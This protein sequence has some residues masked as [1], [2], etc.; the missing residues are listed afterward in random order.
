MPR[1]PR[2]QPVTPAVTPAVP[3]TAVVS[4]PTAYPA[5]D[6]PTDEM[7]PYERVALQAK[8]RRA[9][10]PGDIDADVARAGI[11]DVSDPISALFESVEPEELDPE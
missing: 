8:F 5:E 11:E 3:E 6:D 1:K 7:G 4:V 10:S 9:E 2:R